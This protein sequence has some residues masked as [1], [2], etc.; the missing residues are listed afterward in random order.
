MFSFLSSFILGLEGNFNK[1]SNTV[2]DT[3]NTSYD[4]ASL[5]H[6]EKTAFSI[7]GLPTI[8]PLQTSIKIGQ[9]YKMSDIDIQEIRLFYNCS[10]AGPPLPTNNTN[11]ITG[12]I[13]FLSNYKMNH[14]E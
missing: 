13:C 3:L 2:V 7:N 14:F 10:A 4:Y 5:M 6:Y 9:R 12:Q 11:T 1:Y 8:Q